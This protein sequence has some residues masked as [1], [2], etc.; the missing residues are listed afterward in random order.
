M[1]LYSYL[2]W[3]ESHTS[4]VVQ[5]VLIRQECPDKRMPGI[6][7]IYIHAPPLQ[8]RKYRIIRTNKYFSGD[9]LTI[10]VV[11]VSTSSKQDPVSW[12]CRIEMVGWRVVRGRVGWGGKGN[13]RS[14]GWV[15]WGCE[16]EVRRI[17]FAVNY[18]PGK[19]RTK[20]SGVIILG[21]P[22]GLRDI[23]DP[24]WQ[25]YYDMAAQPMNTKWML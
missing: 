17:D 16:E 3:F 20:L 9:I 22:P 21:R 13:K 11:Q 23:A 8:D 25:T 2:F 1:K 4:W 5:L 10:F 7:W 14:R 18:F 6:S 24:C 15:R 19:I 12:A